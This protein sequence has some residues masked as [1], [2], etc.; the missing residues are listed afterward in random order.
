[1]RVDWD[2]VHTE[3]TFVRER[4]GALINTEVPEEEA[5]AATPEVDGLAKDAPVEAVAE[6]AA[7]PPAQP[8]ATPAAARQSLQGRK[9]DSR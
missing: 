5:A 2:G 6:E 8:S 9:K 4:E 7:R 3:L 1:V